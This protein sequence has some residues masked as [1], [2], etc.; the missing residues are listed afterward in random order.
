VTQKPVRVQGLAGPPPEGLFQRG[1]RAVVPDRDRTDRPD[2]GGDV[3]P[4]QPTPPPGR[5]APEDQDGQVGEVQDDDEVS[6]DAVHAA[7]G[8][9]GPATALSARG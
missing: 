4:D 1:E 6:Q 8:T 9:A 7:D 5:H 2:H 3:E